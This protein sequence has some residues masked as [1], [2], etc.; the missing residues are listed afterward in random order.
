MTNETLHSIRIVCGTMVAMGF[1]INF[2]ERWFAPHALLLETS[3][4]F[5]AWLGWLGWAAAALAAIG[6]FAIDIIS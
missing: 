1:T 5:P 3:P 4:R 6:Y 2:F